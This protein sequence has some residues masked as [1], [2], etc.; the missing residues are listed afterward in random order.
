MRCKAFVLATLV[1]FSSAGKAAVT[2]SAANGFVV[3]TSVAILAAPDEVYRR[4]LEIGD[5][6]DPAHT[7]SGEVHNLSIEAKPMGCFCE[8]LPNGGGVRHMEV[9][10]FV[11]GK[12]LVMTGALGP[13]QSMAATGNMTIQLSSLAAVAGRASAILTT[14]DV[15][16][17][18]TG[19]LPGG[20]NTMAA[21]VDAVT[22]RQFVRLKNLIERGSPDKSDGK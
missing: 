12:T 3:K 21:A 4:L 15:T 22:A 11:P 14:V 13:L 10:N 6:W 18:I 20:M 16:Y 17:A 5:W 2:D 8:K 7:F 1:V 19:Y 9:V